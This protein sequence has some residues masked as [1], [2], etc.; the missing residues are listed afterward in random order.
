MFSKMFFGKYIYAHFYFLGRYLTFQTAKDNTNSTGFAN[1][2]DR[3]MQSMN[4]NET[5]GIC[6]G[7]EIS[8]VFAEIIFSEVDRRILRTLADKKYD[9]FAKI[10]SFVG[11]LMI[12]M[13][14]RRMK[15]QQIG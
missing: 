10:M 9:I 13:S 2:F 11:M 14:L 12:T 6:V 15:Q 4:Y 3:L 8:R 7:P 1:E 5:N